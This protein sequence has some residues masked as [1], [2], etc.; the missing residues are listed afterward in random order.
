LTELPRLLQITT[1]L[2][3]ILNLPQQ[4]LVSDTIFTWKTHILQKALKSEACVVL[5]CKS[6]DEIRITI[7]ISNPLE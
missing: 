6:A 2:N 4:Q 7:F 5:V 3:I 1:E